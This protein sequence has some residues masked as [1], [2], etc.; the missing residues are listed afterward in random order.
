MDEVRLG[1]RT[2]QPRR[3]LIANGQR[4]AL[5]HR[6][7]DIVS[8][9]AEARGGIVTKDELLDAVWPSVTVEENAL[10]VHIVALRKALGPEADR[11]KTIRGVGYQLDVDGASEPAGAQPSDQ[12]H[13]SG[14]PHPGASPEP[15]KAVPI[16]AWHQ[17]RR[18][19]PVLIAVALLVVLMAAG[20]IVGPKLGLWGNDRIP[21]VVRSLA[22]SGSGDSAETALANGITDEL[23]DR[24]R[25]I[26]ELRV[27]TVEVNGS[28][29]EASFRN[30]YIVDGSLR[31]SGDEVRVMMRL[32]D[33]E[34][35]VL[36]SQTFDRRLVGL[37]DMQ[38]RV[39]ASIAD[40][41]SVSFDVGANATEYGGTNN[42]E[43]YAALLE[44]NA[45]SFN[46]DQTV[47]TR[48]IERALALDP[49]YVQAL[50]AQS[51]NY[52]IRLNATVGLSRQQAFELLAKADE[53]SA[54]ALAANPNLWIGHSARVWFNLERSDFGAAA[55]DFRRV[56]E[57]DH[58]NEPGLRSFVAGIEALFGRTTKALS[59]FE[60]GELIDPVGRF[61]SGRASVLRDLG[62]FQEAIDLALEIA[63]GD[64][65]RPR[66]HSDAVF[67]SYLALGKEGDAIRWSEQHFPALAEGLRASRANKDLPTMSPAQLRQWANQR[68]GAG[69]STLLAVEGLFAGFNGHPKLAVELMRVALE[70][71]GGGNI[72]FFW[73]PAMAEAR[74]TDEFERLVTDLGLVKV[75][76]ESGDWGDFCRPVS[77]TE[78]SC[79]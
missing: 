42:P 26:P 60:S 55:K 57:L 70:R 18:F 47:P 68:Y 61:D 3:Q 20:L 16:T 62:R 50:V 56:A 32:S 30:A 7:L 51:Y 71:P 37:L 73:H 5:G 74:K 10:Q 52:E 25:R 22:A 8:V 28:L 59:L 46:P 43:A 69:G 29:P 39:A 67:W 23:I 49:D 44:Y 19:R 76:R 54:R 35:E 2:L 34:G 27:A 11:L 45:T 41:L 9:L 24:L 75:W 64:P 72:G 6:A 40:A 58:G 1:S 4:V 15:P 38:Q 78:I 77:Q 63:G 36:W 53:T 14:Q 21:V 79:R 65:G 66:N 48:H 31:R 13:E 12:F 17:V 33:A